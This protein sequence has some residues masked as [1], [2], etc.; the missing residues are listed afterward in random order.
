MSGH[1]GAITGANLLFYA[2]VRRRFIG[3]FQIHPANIIDRD[4]HDKRLP[5]F[6]F[7]NPAQ[8]PSAFAGRRIQ[9]YFTDLDLDFAGISAWSLGTWA[10]LINGLA[11]LGRRLPGPMPVQRR[12][13]NAGPIHESV[14]DKPNNGAG[15][16]FGG[17]GRSIVPRQFLGDVLDLVF[18]L[19]HVAHSAFP[20]GYNTR[21]TQMPSNNPGLIR[22]EA[23]NT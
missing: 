6:D 9:N 21:S 7:R 8:H 2:L 3:I 19:T 13:D 5:V 15:L 1:W 4:G 23:R 12:N 18:I 16:F 20:P 22:A 11:F 17:P 14:S 10:F